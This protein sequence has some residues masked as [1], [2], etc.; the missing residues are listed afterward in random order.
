MKYLFILVMF[1][2]ISCSP[3]KTANSDVVETLTFSLDSLVQEKCSGGDCAKMR[4]V[5][6]IASGP[7]LSSQIN[8]IIGKEV[9]N[10]LMFGE[11]SSSNRDTLIA[12]YFQ[13]YLEFKS[14]FPEAYGAWEVNIEADVSYQ[15]D[16]TLSVSIDW[17]QYMGGA[18][19]GYGQNF[20][21]LDVITGKPLSRDQIVRDQAKL[22]ALAEKKFREFHEVET[23]VT[24][25]EDGRFFLPDT[26]FFLANS[27]GFEK[28]KFKII[29]VPYEIGPFVMGFTELEFT[30]E[31]LG[32]LVR[33]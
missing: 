18:H 5:W 28:G 21:N 2:M 26:G 13:S 15:S 14:E 29:Y 12:Q 30:R 24:L 16:S 19:P 1:G 17:M 25:E 27:M 3:P 9:T 32:G 6:P 4:L 7:E 31:E 20:L 23:G 22:L 8:E 10:M 33:W 11:S